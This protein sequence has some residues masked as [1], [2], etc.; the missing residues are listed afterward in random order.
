MFIPM[1]RVPSPAAARADRAPASKHG[2]STTSERAA[3]EKCEAILE[4]ALELFSERGFYG[5]AVPVLAEKAKV[6]AG[7]IYR[8]FENK[9]AIVNALYRREK[10]MLGGV[11][12]A[13]FP[14]DAAPRDQFHCFWRSSFELARTHP[15]ALAF[16]ELHHHQSYL[17]EVSRELEA[18][19]LSP[20]YAFFAM[21][22]EKKVT[23]PYAPELLGAIVWGSFIGLIRASWEKR[24]ELTDEAIDQAEGCVW[25][26][27]RR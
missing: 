26:A 9:E 22:A 12:F 8:Y 7:T 19:I 16:L 27:I 11:L 13:K 5:T 15:K 24:L 3:D 1:P 6:A 14:V 17:D 2:G 23:K 4:A 20:A 10:A 18:R 25:E 21:T